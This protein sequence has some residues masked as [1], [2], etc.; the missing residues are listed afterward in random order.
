M[1]RYAVLG[2][3]PEAIKRMERYVE[4]G[5]Q[6]FAFNWACNPEDIPGHIETIAKEIIPHF[7][8]NREEKV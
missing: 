6:H 4:A 3:V 2:P 5:V 8:D 1:F 7:R